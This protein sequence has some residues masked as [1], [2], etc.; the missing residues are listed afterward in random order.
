MIP[1]A[2]N[3]EAFASLPKINVAAQT[4]DK[5]YDSLNAL[6]AVL[7][8]H[9]LNTAYAIILLHQRPFPNNNHS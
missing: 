3:S 5:H 9:H 8:Q 1:P 6:D 2:Y 7:S 4:L